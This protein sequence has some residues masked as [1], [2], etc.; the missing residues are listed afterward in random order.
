MLK[1][2]LKFPLELLLHLPL[3]PESCPPQA[4]SERSHD[5]APAGC[6]TSL[7]WAKAD[8]G[9]EVLVIRLGSHQTTPPLQSAVA[10]SWSVFELPRHLDCQRVFHAG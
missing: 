1:L 5:C 6:S 9:G 10:A 3:V 7:T 2:P 4:M 8:Q